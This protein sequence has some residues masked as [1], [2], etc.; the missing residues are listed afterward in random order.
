MN[1]LVHTRVNIYPI[2][3]G[4]TDFAVDARVKN[5]RQSMSRSQ[6]DLPVTPIDATGVQAVFDFL[7]SADELCMSYSSGLRCP[8]LRCRERYR[9]R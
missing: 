8:H 2:T 6:Q 7:R 4:E 5:G 3:R 1:I 9:R